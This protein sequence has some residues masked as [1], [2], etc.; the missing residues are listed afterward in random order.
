MTTKRS[1]SHYGDLPIQ[2]WMW[3]E[4][5]V[6][7]AREFPT[8]QLHELEHVTWLRCQRTLSHYINFPTRI[9]L[10]NELLGSVWMNLPEVES[11]K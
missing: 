4:V 7:T 3:N 10:V 5:L 11:E 8:M 6:R 1:K 2:Q 9:T